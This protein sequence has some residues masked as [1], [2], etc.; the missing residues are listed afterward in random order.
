MGAAFGLEVCQRRLRPR[1]AILSILYGLGEDQP[2]GHC[3][4]HDLV[5]L[6]DSSDRVPS[7]THSCTTNDLIA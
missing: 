7:W 4:R 1:A 6:E 3:S 2:A 5:T